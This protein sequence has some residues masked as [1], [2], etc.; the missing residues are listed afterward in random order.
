MEIMKLK[1]AMNILEGS[2]E[3]GLLI[4]EVRSNLVMAKKDA[5]DIEDVAGIPGRIT[6]LNGLPKASAEPDYGASS[7][8]ARLVL[9][10]MKYDPEMRSALNMK[11]HPILVDICSKL[12]LMVSCYNRNQEP[13]KVQNEEGSSIPWGVKVAVERIGAVPDVIYHTG[14]WGKESM[15][16][17]LGTAA[18]DVAKMAVCLA[19]LFKTDEGHKVLFPPSRGSYKFLSSDVECVFCA[20]KDG[21]LLVKKRLLYEDKNT[22]VLMNLFTYNR[23]HLVVVP[24]QHI[25]DLNEL[26]AEE[27]KILFLMVQKTVQLLQKVIKPDG[28]TIRLKLGKAVDS[29]IEHLHVQV[30]PGFMIESGLTRTTAHTRIIEESLD[31]AY[32]RFKNQIEILGE[33]KDAL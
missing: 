6:V 22:M 27:I 7:H 18:I 16:V 19:K 33:E 21:N 28:V 31:D 13:I 26:D 14:S 5:H 24:K 30:L 3:F 20:I 25:K 12:G 9:S 29:N 2:Q 11:Y 1:E 15:L 17:L 4:P 32:T 8:M 10:I 23:V